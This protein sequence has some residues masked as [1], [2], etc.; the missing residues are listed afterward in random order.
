MHIHPL[1][2][3]HVIRVC[4]PRYGLNVGP[5]VRALETSERPAVYEGHGVLP[6]QVVQPIDSLG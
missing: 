3:S 5:G 1:P 6:S 2:L 4:P